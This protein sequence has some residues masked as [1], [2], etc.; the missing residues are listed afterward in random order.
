MKD[1]EGC[2]FT[3]LTERGR[4]GNFYFDR[5]MIHVCSYCKHETV[6][7]LSVPRKARPS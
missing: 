7:D 3:F 5:F 1:C 6:V 4:R 2:G